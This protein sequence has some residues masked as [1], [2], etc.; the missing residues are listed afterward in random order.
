MT[1]CVARRDWLRSARE[2]GFVRRASLA[3]FGAARLASFGA[4]A[5]LRSARRA[6]LRSA[7]ALGFVRRARLASFGCAV[8]SLGRFLPQAG[9]VWKNYLRVNGLPGG[10]SQRGQ[11]HAVEA[12]TPED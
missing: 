9:E 5:W 1:V 3:S 10:E 8:S 2:L 4:R 7:R 6:W 12:G 11:E